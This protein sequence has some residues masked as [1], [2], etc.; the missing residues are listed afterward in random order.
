MA[1]ATDKMEILKQCLIDI[2][3]DEAEIKMLMNDDTKVL[4]KSL[5]EKRQ[6]LLAGIHH[7][8][9]L[10]DCLDYLVYQIRKGGLCEN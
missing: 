2:G 6:K 10:V 1:E 8:Q 4:L 5:G 7:D 9:K 3:Y